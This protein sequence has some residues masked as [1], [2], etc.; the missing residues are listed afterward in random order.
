M[1]QVL[2]ATNR[3][4]S[5]GSHATTGVVWQKAAVALQSAPTA[6]SQEV[7]IRIRAESRR[8]HFPLH[9][10][11][12]QAFP[13]TAHTTPVMMKDVSLQVSTECAVNVR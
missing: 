7:R 8:L 6:F 9:G 3:R 11:P 10:I 1:R 5:E 4:R 13:E 2:R 12:P